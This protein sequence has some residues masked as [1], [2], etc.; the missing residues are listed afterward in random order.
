MSCGASAIGYFLWAVG[1]GGSVLLLFINCHSL[2]TAGSP[3]SFFLF[4]CRQRLSVWL[5]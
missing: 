3:V 4:A 5:R 1:M 2:K